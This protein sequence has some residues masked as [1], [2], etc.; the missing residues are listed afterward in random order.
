M[1]AFNLRAGG[2]GSSER[3]PYSRG[4]V[5]VAWRAFGSVMVDGLV[6]CL[7]PFWVS[8]ENLALRQSVG[9]TASRASGDAR[10]MARADLARMKRE[11]KPLARP[12]VVLN[13]YH[14]WAGLAQ[15]LADRLVRL[16]SG[17]RGDA[18]AVSYMHATSFCAAHAHAT[19]EVCGWLGEGADVDVV[20]ISMGGLVGRMCA[21]NTRLRVARVFTI[22]TPHRG[23]QWASILAMDDAARCMRA[24]SAFLQELDAA[25]LPEIHAYGQLRDG[26]VGARQTYPHVGPHMGPHMGP[27]VGQHVGQHAG[28]HIG[29]PRWM[30]GTRVLS[31][32]TGTHN[33]IILCSIARALRGEEQLFDFGSDPPPRD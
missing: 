22:G 10:A 27:H 30:S 7:R 13:G 20:G 3:A 15:N 18:I 12:M 31:H 11:L 17:Q 24:G 32:F 5:D 19:R 2:T 29:R 25:P 26:I 4:V 28:Q 33:P 8:E 6:L 14:A 9:H 16:T 23:A 1:S 21:A